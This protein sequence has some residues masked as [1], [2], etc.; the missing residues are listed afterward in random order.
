MSRVAALTSDVLVDFVVGQRWSGGEERFPEWARVAGVAYEDD[1]LA[2]PIVEVGSPAGTHELYLLAVGFDRDEPYDALLDPTH[3]RRLA[4]LCGVDAP[5][6]SVREMGVEQS[7]STVV[8]DGR[9][10]L[11]LLRRLDAGPSPEVELLEAL[12]AAGF[13]NA[14]ALEGVFEHQG[15]PLTATLAVVTSLVPALGAGWELALDA[16]AADDADWLPLRAGRLGEVTGAMHNAFAGTADLRLAPEEA[17]AEAMALLVATIEEDAERLAT[18]VADSPV[19]TRVAEVRDLLNELSPVG[20]PGL[21]IRVHGDYHL[22]QV[23]WSKAGDWVV[24]DFEGE[25][26]RPLAER[27]QRTS[28][29]RDVAGMMR[30]FA[31]V[32]DGVSRLR[33][34]EAPIGWEDACRTAFVEGYT[35]V[36]D[37]RLL[38]GAGVGRLLA[39]FELQKLLYELRYEVNHRPD[40]VGIPLAGLERM[41][42]VA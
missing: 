6:E 4:A 42:A 19:A 26:A 12:A 38:P 13:P 37:D 29:L 16:I 2:L 32:A 21:A 18:E 41:L 8:L 23:L 27:R 1:V 28:G 20:P 15:E 11:K 3:A 7:N 31:Y 40:W 39:L 35:D 5:C 14:P 22:G 10:V 36:V 25:P 17:S 9:H 33:G 30:S 24:I 34:V